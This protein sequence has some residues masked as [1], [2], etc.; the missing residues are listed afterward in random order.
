MSQR[1]SERVAALDLL[2]GLAAFAVAIP[3]F[4]VQQSVQP[5]LSE[6]ASV[7]AVEVFFVL[8]G[9]V[10]APQILACIADGR[11]RTLAIFLVRRWMRTIPAFLLA[12]LVMSLLAGTLGTADFWR[13]AFYVQNLFGQLNAYDFFPIAWSLSI[14]EW[15]YVTFPLLLLAVTTIARRRRPGLVLGMAIALLV[16]CA[17][18][19]LAA[20]DTEH[21]GYEVRRVVI[22]RIDSIVYGFLLYVALSRRPG[23][24]LD[25]VPLAGCLLAL[26]AVTALAKAAT[27]AAGDGSAAAKH[28]FPFVAALFGC[29]G[30]ATAV[31]ARHFVEGRG[32]LAWTG[33][34]LGRISYSVYLFHLLWIGVLAGLLAGLPLAAQLA[35]YVVAVALFARLVY[36]WVERPILAARPSYAPRSVRPRRIAERRPFSWRRFAWRSGLATASVLVALGSIEGGLRIA[37]SVPATNALL[38][39]VMV[40]WHKEDYTRLHGFSAAVNKTVMKPVTGMRHVSDY[41]EYDYEISTIACLG[42]YVRSR[43]ANGGVDAT[44]HFGDSAT[45]GFGVEQDQTFVSR[46]DAAVPGQINFA[47]AGDRITTMIDQAVEL[48]SRRDVPRPRAIV[49]DIFLANDILEVAQEVKVFHADL[50]MAYQDFAALRGPSGGEG[51]P[52]TARRL[53]NAWTAT[54]LAKHTALGELIDHRLASVVTEQDLQ[55]FTNMPGYLFAPQHLRYFSGEAA[56]SGPLREEV[57]AVAAAA[58]AHLAKLRAVYAGPVVFSYLPCKELALLPSLQPYRDVIGRFED[59]TAPDG[60]IHYDYLDEVPVSALPPGFFKLDSHFNPGGLALYAE[61]LARVLA[62]LVPPLAKAAAAP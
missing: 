53:Y 15:Y 25:R 5:V 26:G 20:G 28:L 48:L 9:Y 17:V 35:L 42:Y 46:I 10:L 11:P 7:L 2:R 62:R 12:L 45:F 43:C 27:V 40:G 38:T 14:E 39:N 50:R 49:F 55:K 4:L 1:A 31:R 33:L 59:A 24:L 61:H 56:S 60:V 36:G 6:A 32:W 19:R 51:G 41:G 18:L 58:A 37:A 54:A 52:T 44:W 3:H 57:D 13:Y 29:A 30:V 23:A 21:W 34:F 8:S 22:F 47:I 16:A